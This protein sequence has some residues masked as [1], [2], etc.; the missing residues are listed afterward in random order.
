MKFNIENYESMTPEE[1]VA[2]LEAYEPD[3][4][5]F[6]SKA[7]FDKTASEA[8]SYK[9]QLREKMTEDEQQKAKE[10]EDKLAVEARAAELEARVRELEAEKAVSSYVNS[11]LAMGYDEKLAKSS[12]EAIVKG[13]METVFKNQKLNAEAREKAL[14]AELLKQTP[15]PASGNGTGA[16]TKEQ[17]DSMGYAERVSLYDS[18]PELYNELNGGNDNGSG[19]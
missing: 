19:H 1:K 8:A 5:G 16:V 14:K 12:A 17:F 15:D 3:M 13:D 7:T 9:K 18:N 4:S 11:Y 2:A 10:A 6:V